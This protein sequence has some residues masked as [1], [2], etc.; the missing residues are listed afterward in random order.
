MGKNKTNKRKEKKKKKKKEKKSLFFWL[1]FP[2]KKPLFFQ[3]KTKIGLSVFLSEREGNPFWNFRGLTLRAGERERER[4]NT[5]S[6]QPG[7]ITKLCSKKDVKNPL[8]KT[9]QDFN[10][11]RTRTNQIR[12]PQRNNGTHPK[13]TTFVFDPLGDVLF[14]FFL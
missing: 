4:D 8:Q 5:L 3:Q 12:F 6:I 13:L 14:L 10:P 9:P 1:F 2:S 7:K 11:G